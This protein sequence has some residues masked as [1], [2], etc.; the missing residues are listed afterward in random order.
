MT[1]KS[2][3]CQN[4]Y[5]YRIVHH[6]NHRIY[7]LYVDI[8]RFADSV[9]RTGGPLPVV[10]DGLSISSVFVIQIGPGLCRKCDGYCI[11][12]TSVM[13]IGSELC[14]DCDGFCK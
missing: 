9:I 5:Q 6:F 12:D 10:Y 13:Q 2:K 14:R 3:D 11:Q 7:F 1:L 4:H 8:D